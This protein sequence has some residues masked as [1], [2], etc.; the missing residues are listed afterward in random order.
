MLCPDCQPR[1][2]IR[3]LTAT[4]K[5]KPSDIHREMISVYMENVLIVQ[6]IWLLRKHFLEG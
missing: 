2:V 6:L 3:Y 1:T 5:L 4:Q